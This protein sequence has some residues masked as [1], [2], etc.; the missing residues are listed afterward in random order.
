MLCLEEGER[1]NVLCNTIAP[2][3]ASRLTET[4]MPPEMLAALKPG[5]ITPW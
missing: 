3:A 5:F 4:I 1:K 2:L